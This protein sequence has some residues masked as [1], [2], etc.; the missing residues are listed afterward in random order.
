MCDRRAVARIDLAA[1]RHNAGRLVRAAGGAR[2]MAVVKADGYGHGAIPAARAALEGGASALA[3]AAVAEAEALR[4]AGIDAPLLVM[5]PLAGD[6]W[7]RALSAGAQLAVWT[8]DAV[9]RAAAAAG[10][11]RAQLHL[12][13]DTGMGRL[14]AR[15]EDVAALADAA[16]AEGRV[17][18]VGLMTHFAAADETEGENAAFMGEQLL[19]F[20]AAA[21]ALRPRFPGVALHA[22]NSAATFRDP[23]AALDMVRC[24]I[25]LYGCSPFGGDPAELDLRPAMSLV[26]YLAAT[27][28]VLSRESV[29]YGRAWRAARGTRVAVVPVGYA[30]GYSRALSGR[31]EVLVAGR[32]VPVVGTISM[33]QL[34][35]DLGPGAG[36]PVGEEVVLLGAQGDERITA[37][38]LAARRGTISYEVT[39]AV[40]ARVPRVH[41][42]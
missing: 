40:G 34:T 27:K 15:A 30:D 39:C 4:A 32:R 17:E 31:A 5:G 13:L 37:E 3:V 28:T 29:G 19:R 38:E 8:P 12:K 42:G 20:R 2:L 21:A 36:D 7:G 1:I 6:E 9:A 16:A 14:G 25:A 26:S 35:V 24:G 33:D 18:V 23:A 22:A 10:G 41:E 11:G